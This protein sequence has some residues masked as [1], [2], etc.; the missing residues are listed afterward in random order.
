MMADVDAHL[1]RVTTTRQ[2]LVDAREAYLN[3]ILAAQGAGISSTK[4]AAAAGL[5]EAAIRQ[6]VKR[7][8][9]N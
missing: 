1:N 4:I 6:T 3:A 9:G 5:T 8:S 2:V 7:N